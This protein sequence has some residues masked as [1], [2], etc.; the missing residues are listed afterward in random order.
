MQVRAVRLHE[1]LAPGHDTDY[2]MWEPMDVDDVVT[3][4]SQ[5]LRRGEIGGQAQRQRSAF[6][7]PSPCCAEVRQVDLVDVMPGATQQLG[8]DIGYPRDVVDQRDPG[9]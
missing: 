8:L 2:S 6:D 1:K 5:A 3:P 9:H 7:W 4:L